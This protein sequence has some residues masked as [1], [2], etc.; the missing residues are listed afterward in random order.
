M[1]LLSGVVK[2][3]A[4][5]D[6]EKPIARNHLFSP[7]QRMSQHGTGTDKGTELLRTVGAEVQ[8]DKGLQPS[9]FASN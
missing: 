1:Q 3:R 7:V 2:V 4:G 5:H 8:P 6:R 9:S